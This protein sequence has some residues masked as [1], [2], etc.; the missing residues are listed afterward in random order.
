MASLMN[1]TKHLKKNEQQSS[2]FSKKVEEE[3]TLLPHPMGPILSY[4]KASTKKKTT[5]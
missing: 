4:I 1:S 5:D 2:N 3:G